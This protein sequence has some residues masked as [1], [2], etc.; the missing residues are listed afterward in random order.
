M[1]IKG[2]ASSAV[3]GLLFVSLL[4][5]YLLLPSNGLVLFLAVLIMLVSL[6]VAQSQRWREVAVM[7]TF[8]GL[9]SLV[10]AMLVGRALFGTFGSVA[11]PLVWAL[12]LLGLFNWISNRMLRVPKDRAVLIMRPYSGLVYQAATPV[13]PPILPYFERRVAEIPLYE[14]SK[15]VRIEKVNTKRFNV[16]V[17]QVHIHYRVVEPQRAMVGIPNRGQFQTEIAKE[18]S[19]EYA[20]ARQDVTFWERLLGKQ[21][22]LEV[23]DIVRE[24]VYN[25][26]FA[27]NP[28]EVYQ[29]REDLAGEVQERLNKLVSR[30]GVDIVGLEFERVDVDP[31]VLQRLN[32]ASAR[33][34][35]TELKEVEAKREATRIRLTGEAQAQVEATRVMSLVRALQETGVDLSPEVLREIVVEALHASTEASLE[36]MAVRPLP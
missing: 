5:I 14:L 7:A 11:V 15:D 31:G 4:V 23:E 13:A 36:N 26:T 19:L 33:L 32:K 22:E 35:D 17:I 6:I 12:V 27:Q 3:L 34:D 30:W 16:D 8:A 9:V 24:V 28:M 10:A 18:M 1:A 21:M 29:R 25:N 2:V 20:K